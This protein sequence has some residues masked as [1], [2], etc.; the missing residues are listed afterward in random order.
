MKVRI[1]PIGLVALGL[2]WL[3]VDVYLVIG[4]AVLRET[5]LGVIARFLDRMPAMI[6]NPIFR[7]LWAIVLL[8]WGLPLVL[9]FRWL[10]DSKRSD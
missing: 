1:R 8:G 3:V 6:A 4:N 2:V 10:L 5:R 7:L 9:G